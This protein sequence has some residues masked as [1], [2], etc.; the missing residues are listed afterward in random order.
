MIAAVL[1]IWST[2]R[3]GGGNEHAFAVSE[4]TQIR[5]V[6]HADERDERH[7]PSAKDSGYLWQASTFT[8][9]AARDEGVF[10]ELETLGLS[11]AFPPMLGWVIE[12][13]AR[14]LGRSSVE[15]S[16]REFRRAVESHR[17]TTAADIPTDGC[18]R[19]CFARLFDSFA[20]VSGHG[21]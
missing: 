15:V 9:Y 1:D 13:I 16:L 18:R 11:R 3:Y 21:S 5:Q 12:P 20:K 17:A 10:V 2:V 14:R 7:L 4:A 6:E 8:R 19:R